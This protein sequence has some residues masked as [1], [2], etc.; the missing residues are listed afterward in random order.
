MTVKIELGFS[1]IPKKSI[2]GFRFLGDLG[3][4]V[5]SNWGFRSL[6]DLGITVKIKLGFSVNPQEIELRFSVSSGRFGDSAMELGFGV[7]EIGDF[8][9]IELGF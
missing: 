7:W 9:E 3:V 5:K 8:W 4:S 1:V 2:W 6:G